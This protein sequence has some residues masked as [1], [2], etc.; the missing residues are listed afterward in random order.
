LNNRRGKGDKASK[1][2]TKRRTVGN[3]SSSSVLSLEEKEKIIQQFMKQF[4]DEN[5]DMA[6]DE[7]ML[8]LQ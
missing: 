2:V 8:K 1:R 4:L 3:N 6:L 5:P 7:V